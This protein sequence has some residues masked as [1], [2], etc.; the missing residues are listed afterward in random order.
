MFR[1]FVHAH[2]KQYNAKWRE[3]RQSHSETNVKIAFDWRCVSSFS[4][5]ILHCRKKKRLRIV[6]GSCFSWPYTV[7]CRQVSQDLASPTTCAVYAGRTEQI[8][9]SLISFGTLF[10]PK[11]PATVSFQLRENVFDYF[12]TGGWFFSTERSETCTGKLAIFHVDL[13]GG[14]ES[15][16]RADDKTRTLVR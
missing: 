8:W 15:S 13:S 14:N 10:K 6:S 1:I 16:R 9:A 2:G 11:T 5:P 4:L 3:Q 7:W 12:L